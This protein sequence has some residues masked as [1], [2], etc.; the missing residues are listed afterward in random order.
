[1][2]LDIIIIRR[3]KMKKL[4][5]FGILML[6]SIGMVSAYSCYQES[7]NTSNQAGTDGS[8]EQNY[9]GT[10]SFTPGN[11]GYLYINYSI[12]RNA[13]TNSLIQIKADISPET[14]YTIPTQCLSRGHILSLRFMTSMDYYHCLN[15]DQTCSQLFCR[16]QTTGNWVNVTNYV[17]QNAGG[18][19]TIDAIGQEYTIDGD[20]N[21]AGGWNSDGNWYVNITG[22]EQYAQLFEEGIYWDIGVCNEIW[23]QHINCT[24]G[25][26]T[27]TYTDENN[28]GT[29]INLP[30]DNGSISSCARL[31]VTVDGYDYSWESLN[32]NLS[33]DFRGLTYDPI[34]NL[35]YMGMSSGRFGYYN[36]S[37]Q[38]FT[39][40]STT[41]PANWDGTSTNYAVTYDATN[42]LAYTCSQSG[43]LGVYDPTTNIWTTLSTTD[44]ANW[45]GT[46]NCWSIAYDSTDDLVFTGAQLGKFG[47]YNRT[48]NVWTDLRSADPADWWATTNIES[49]V[50]DQAHNILF[51]GGGNGVSGLPQDGKFGYYNLSDGVLYDLSG[52]A[53]A[54]WNVWSVSNPG[55]W[56]GIKDVRAMALDS[57]HNKLY[58][59]SFASD[60]LG[61]YDI[62]ANTWSDLSSSDT[63]NWT[64]PHQFSYDIVYDS[65]RNLVYTGHFQ[66][67]AYVSYPDVRAGLGVYNPVT[68]IWTD[69]SN[70]FTGIN[71][72]TGGNFS[73]SLVRSLAYDELN[74]VL[75]TGVNSDFS[76]LLIVPH[77]TPTPTPTQTRGTGTSGRTKALIAQAG[78]Q[79]T[80]DAVSS[81]SLSNMNNTQKAIAGTVALAIL[82]GGYSLLRPKRRRR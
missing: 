20:W 58:T 68:N 24:N 72:A 55:G 12:P 5:L 76:V 13:T 52:T 78:N 17:N 14:N 46:S 59:K 61:V 43:K 66:T 51:V 69:L 62:T 47:V 44:P 29:I 60:I 26:Q 10:Y 63:T 82:I 53:V 7:A 18:G 54:G 6:V 38:T 30:I 15:G 48:S 33:A 70:S 49:L 23:N 79:I 80:G 19:G 74:N 31:P 9:S 56:T 21:T 50:Y 34:H 57:A 73:P 41:D 27:I 36:A 40:L 67:T 77:T 11:I 32:I 81:F 4:L 28:C 22:G 35:V 37:S 39:D 25:I 42:N 16:N 8:C 75:Y 3:T 45:M 2:G 64:Y 1:M 71:I 65:T